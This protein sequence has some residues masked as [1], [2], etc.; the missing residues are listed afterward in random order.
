MA[1]MGRQSRGWL[2]VRAVSN[3]TYIRNFQFFMIDEADKI[4]EANFEDEMKIFSLLWVSMHPIRMLMKK[5]LGMRSN[6]LF[7]TDS[8]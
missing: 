5:L 3:D 2:E 6:K 7:H 1:I 8:R 4:L